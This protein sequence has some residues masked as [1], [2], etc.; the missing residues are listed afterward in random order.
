[1]LWLNKANIEQ[2]YILTHGET[3]T[4]RALTTD[5]VTSKTEARQTEDS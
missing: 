3:S 5:D 4:E 1:M 2:E